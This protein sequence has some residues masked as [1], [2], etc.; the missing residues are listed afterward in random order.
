MR[1]I[2]STSS[3]AALGLHAT[4]DRPVVLPNG[5]IGVRGEAQ[6]GGNSGRIPAVEHHFVELGPRNVKKAMIIADF[7]QLLLLVPRSIDV[8]GLDL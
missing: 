5:E 7:G 2:G 6:N 1:L 4:K 3:A 8:F